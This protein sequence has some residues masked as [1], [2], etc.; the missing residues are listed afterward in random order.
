[1]VQNLF[2]LGGIQRVVTTILNELVKDPS[3]EVTVIMPFQMKGKK[4]FSLDDRVYLNAQ[5]NFSED[6]SHKPVRYLLAANKR[7][8]FL[9]QRFLV[10]FVENIRFSDKEKLRYI[11]YFNKENFDVVI[12]AGVEYS[13]L[14]GAI[15]TKIKAKTIGWQHSTFDSYFTKRGATGYGINEYCKVMY[16]R[17]DDVWVLTN[18]D[19]RDFDFHFGLNC[20]VFYNP[21]S[22]HTCKMSKHEKGNI[23]FAGRLEIKHKGLDYLIDIMRCITQSVPDSLLTIVGDGPAHDWMKQEIIKKGLENKIELV[24]NTNNVYEYYEKASVILQTSRWEG[25]GMTIIE[26]MSCGVPVVAF[27]NYGPD[28][29]VR[30]GIDGFLIDHYEIEKFAQKVIAILN[31]QNLCK[32]LGKNGM[33]RAKAFSIE[34]ILPVFIS[35]LQDVVER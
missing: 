14:L 17:L 6:R 31:D 25:F 2:T 12:G 10:K 28:E 4:L 19:K 27:H 13:L 3:F 7:L 1:M 30:N 9:D 32:M 24:G 22:Q 21:I 23:L 8:G 20:R 5:E 33:E 15:S 35:Y 26:A 34:K 16:S 11:E 29:I 18:S